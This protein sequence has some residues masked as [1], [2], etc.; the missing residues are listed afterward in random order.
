[1][2]KT[3]NFNIQVP[4]L[5][6]VPDITQVSDAIQDLEDALAGTLEIMNASI[7]GSGLT[8]SSVARQ[9]KRTKYYDGMSIRFL[10]PQTITANTLKTVVVDDL[11]QQVI[12]VPFDIISG[13]YVD[14]TYRGTSFTAHPVMIQKSEST[15]SNSNETVATSK[16]VKKVNERVSNEVSELNKNKVSKSGDTMNGG[17]SIDAKDVQLFLKANGTLTGKLAANEENIYLEN[18]FSDK[19]IILKKNGNAVY[20][21]NNLKTNSKEVVGA[22]NEL[23]DGKESAFEKKS[24]FNLDKTDNA[25]N[26]TNKLFTA[27]GAYNLKNEVDTKVSK[28]GDTMTGDL[29]IN[30]GLNE[31]NVRLRHKNGSYGAVTKQEDRLL[32]WNA[33]SSRAVTLFD[34]GDVVIPANNLKTNNKEVISSINELYTDKFNVSGGT[35]HGKVS[36]DAKEAQLYLASNR[37]EIGKIYADDT[38]IVIQNFKKS[39]HYFMLRGDGTAMLSASNLKTDSKEIVSAIN[40]IKKMIGEIQAGVLVLDSPLESGQSVRVDFKKP[41]REIPIVV[42]GTMSGNMKTTLGDSSGGRVMNID[43]GGFTYH[44]GWARSLSNEIRYVAMTETK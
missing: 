10:C 21:A 43:R 1:M 34:S 3:K 5:G 2:R 8:L 11:P 39:G 36:I 33:Q 44:N 31:T 20:P 38:D 14:I 16:A 18:F 29:D 23:V 42:V 37:S 28:S 25:I 17:L 35:I 12:T 24:G 30:S 22:I 15:D 32:L 9:T 40:E 26:D 19:S 27:K 6:D 4:E 13:E 7:Q 41:F